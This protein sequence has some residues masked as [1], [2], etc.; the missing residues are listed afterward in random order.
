[1]GS[2][3]PSHGISHQISHGISQTVSH[4]VPLF[5]MYSQLIPKFSRFPNTS[6]CFP[7]HL[8]VSQ[9]TPLLPN[10][11]HYCPIHPTLSQ[12]V[13]L[14]P[15]TSHCFPKH[16][17]TIA[18]YVPLFPNVSHSF[19]KHPIVSRNTPRL[20]KTYH[21]SHSTL[22]HIPMMIRMVPYSLLVTSYCFTSDS[23]KC[24]PNLR[25]YFLFYLSNFLFSA[26]YLLTQ[27]QFRKQISSTVHRHYIPKSLVSMRLRFIL[28]FLPTLVVRVVPACIA[29]LFAI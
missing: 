28:L 20:P 22:K 3:R 29:E 9:N 11:S 18:Q 23:V 27:S 4:Y 7:K 13:P 1:M 10:K 15:K 5:P 24:H 19:P 6:H 16:P 12:R 26:T 8:I 21:Y 25:S 17:P 2:Q 14:L